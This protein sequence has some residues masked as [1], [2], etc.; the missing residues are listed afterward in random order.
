MENTSTSNIVV[1][2]TVKFCLGQVGLVREGVVRVIYA[3]GSMLVRVQN[4]LTSEQIIMPSEVIR[5]RGPRGVV[6]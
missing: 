3:D 4:S 2:S 5:E 1:G 6:A